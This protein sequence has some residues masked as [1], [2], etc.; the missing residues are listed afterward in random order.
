M[1]DDDD[2]D[3][4]LE[5]IGGPPAIGKADGGAAQGEEDDSR[6]PSNFIKGRKHVS[7]VSKPFKPPGPA[8]TGTF[9]YGLKR[10][11]ATDSGNKGKEK[12][13][14]VDEDLVAA[15]GST[16]TASQQKDGPSDTPQSAPGTPP[17]NG[18]R[19]TLKIR[20]VDASALTVA[21]AMEE[22]WNDLERK[23]QEKSS[24]PESEQDKAA[25]AAA[26]TAVVPP[27][28]TLKTRATIFN[29]HEGDSDDMTNTQV[30]T[31]ERLLGDEE[32]A[33]AWAQERIEASRATLAAVL[34][35]EDEVPADVDGE[36]RSGRSRLALPGTLAAH[37]T[38]VPLQI[39]KS[40]P[41]ARRNCLPS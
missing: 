35:K 24:A 41:S 32:Q 12:A 26:A 38:S 19:R 28:R 23:Q 2:D 33:Q 34:G 9:G 10:D 15:F 16:S 40:A 37:V 18:A 36:S 39:L 11:A 21:S 13:E 4:G 3:D 22:E 25:S 17:Q 7:P 8:K 29:K 5:I 20:K 6:P 1:V 14:L 30:Q 27:R 31:L